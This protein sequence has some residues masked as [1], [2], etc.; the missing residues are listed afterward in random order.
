LT[1]AAL[2]AQETT[3]GQDAACLARIAQW[4]SGVVTRLDEDV[5]G[6]GKAD[7]IILLDARP[8]TEHSSPC[9]GTQPGCSL[10]LTVA[11]QQSSVQAIWQRGSGFGD[12][13]ISVIDITKNDGRKEVVV[14][15]RAGWEE[16]PPHIHDVWVMG[17]P[18]TTR[19]KGSTYGR[20]M[21]SATG[22]GFLL[23][24]DMR[25]VDK[26]DTVNE[27]HL[28]V[29]FKLKDQTLLPAGTK[30]VKTVPDGCPG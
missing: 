17:A 15:Q 18:A 12:V 23:M 11:G 10:I 16:D 24:N 9:E 2:T 21:L 7:S 13:N 8:K 3:E 1:K 14:A 20:G 25:C 22:D 29:R 27:E 6:D 4:K 26:N 28:E 30:V 5:N 19:V